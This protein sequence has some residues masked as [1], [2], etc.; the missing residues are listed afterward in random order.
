MGQ[1]GHQKTELTGQL[2]FDQHLLFVKTSMD[3]R[4]FTL[5]VPL[6]HNIKCLLLYFTKLFILKFYFIFSS[7]GF[8]YGT[9]GHLMKSEMFPALIHK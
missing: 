5:A 3:S 8:S 9:T 6:S 4:I 1:Y 2:I 7:C